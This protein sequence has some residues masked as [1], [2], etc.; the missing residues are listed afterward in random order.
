MWLMSSKVS[1]F[2]GRMDALVVR[3][4]VASLLFCHIV[5]KGRVSLRELIQ[6]PI[7]GPK[8]TNLIELKLIRIF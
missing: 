2:W 1:P 7:S 5:L 6:P 8:Q 4:V 3:W